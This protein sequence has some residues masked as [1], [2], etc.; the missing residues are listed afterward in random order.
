M[1]KQLALK[2]IIVIS[3]GG[4]LFSGFLSY[5]ELFAGSC[6]LGFVRCGVN[7]GPIFGMPACVYGLVMYTVVFIT[8]LLGY[9]S[10][11]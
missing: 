4:M 7:T 8:S 11:Q 9:K 6:N 10:K 1:T 2:T 5:R 3:L